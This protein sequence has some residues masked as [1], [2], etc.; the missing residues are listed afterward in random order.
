MEVILL[1][2]EERKAWVKSYAQVKQ[3]WLEKCE[4][5]GKDCKGL[6]GDIDRLKEKYSGMSNE[7]LVKSVIDNP[8]K[9]IIEF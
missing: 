6:L 5:S 1:T 2:P 4:Q 8:V 7:E 3:H 9:G